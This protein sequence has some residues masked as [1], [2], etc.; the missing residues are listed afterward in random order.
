MIPNRPLPSLALTGLLLAVSH[1]AAAPLWI[2]A[3]GKTDDQPVYFRHSFEVKEV[4][5]DL[6][7]QLTCDNLAEVFINGKP[8]G[9]IA[10][11]QEPI[12]AKISA[13]VQPG[14]NVIA[15]KAQ[16]QGGS[17]GLVARVDLGGKGS[18]VLDETST[19]WKQSSTAPEGWERPGFDDKSWS[20][21]AAVA[22]L[23]AGPWGNVFSRPAGGTLIDPADLNLLPGFKADLVYTVPKS[24]QGSWVS[25]T[26]DDKQRLIAG[27]Q[28]GGLYRVTLD[29]KGAASV[30]P[31]AVKTGNAQGL[32]FHNHALYLVRNG[33]A[34]GLYRLRDTNGDDQ[35]DEEVLLRKFDGDGEHGPH[36]VIPSPDGQSLY[37]V[38]GNF[39]KTPDPDTFRPAKLWAEDQLITRMTDAGGHDPHI[40]APAGW[41][42]K[43]DLDGKAWELVSMGF[44]NTYD[45]AFNHDGELFAYDSDMEWDIGLPWYRPTRL[46]HAVP[47]AEFG[48]R[49][50]SG[51]FPV[52]FPDTVP[53]IV[54]IGPGSPV[55]VT[56]GYGSKFPAKYQNALFLLDWTYGTMYA[57]H[58]APDG[59]TYSGVKEEFLSGKPLPLTDAVIRPADGAM[60]FLIGGRGN[61]SGLYR[62]TWTGNAADTAPVAATPALTPEAKLRRQIESLQLSAPSTQV[63]DTVWPHLDHADRF[64]R[65][66]ARTVIEHQ[67]VASWKD[68][69]L[70][71]SRPWAK[72]T[73]LLA[74][75]RSAGPDKSLLLPILHGLGVNEFSSLNE[76]QQ[77]AVL[78]TASVA[79]IRLGPLDDEIKAR[80]AEKLDTLYPA[81]TFALNKALCELL[82]SLGSRQVVPKSMALMGSIASDDQ[83]DLANKELLLRSEGYAKGVLSAQ[84]SKP[85][86]QQIAYAYALR[87]ATAGW[88]AELYRQYF[89]WFNT[90]RKF[91][92]GNSLRGF[93]ENMRKDALTRVP[94]NLKAELDSISGELNSTPVELPQPI[95][96]GKAWTTEELLALTADGL[97]GRDFAAGK[98]AYQAALCSS[99]H[100]FGNEYGGVGPELSGIA[101]RYTMRDLLDNIMEPSKVISDQYESTLIE[102]TDGSSVVGRIVKEEG[103]VVSVAENPLAPAQV[104]TI[105]QSNIKT[106]AKYPVSAMPPALLYSLN[107]DEVLDLFAF[108]LSGG[109]P[110][111][112]AFKK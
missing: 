78:R 112:K 32:L 82:V 105:N 72:I 19:D 91:D 17:A 47:G 94:A 104:T 4:T 35:F 99:C 71:E 31:L 39:T 80:A 50:G 55:G 65:F 10:E 63:L 7:L 83:A 58:L 56:F 23:G 61:Q 22:S 111:D 12:S 77:L 95:G 73:A 84:S 5:P 25:L 41:I 3:P 6:R 85:N 79:L 97:H 90:A 70:A 103:D 88:S 14:R 26:L 57:V 46:C 86:R 16:N 20:G 13:M 60:Y 29:D 28:N 54:N 68:R 27:D 37:V 34:S 110:N 96:P 98:R 48:F 2:W 69:A 106:R 36:A 9:K 76:E 15:V 67:P 107:K 8:A 89:R 101:N 44:R 18:P 100:R 30:Q 81:K 40:M 108:L 51:K 53:P 43:T 64:I 1:A 52:T 75:T 93:I 92:G 42:A 24:A 109:D 62:V 11:W 45:I 74:L 38:A 66:A 87:E 59:A 102:K 49:N 33:G 21:S